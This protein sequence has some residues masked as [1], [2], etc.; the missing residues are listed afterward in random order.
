MIFSLVLGTRIWADFVLP[1][2]VVTSALHEIVYSCTRISKKKLTSY[3]QERLPLLS[4][5][6]CS[7]GIGQE[8]V[9]NLH[10][11]LSEK[12]QLKVLCDG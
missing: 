6:S 4:P 9:V 10:E 3:L 2:N 11:H 12:F 5:K 1:V 8:I 7:L